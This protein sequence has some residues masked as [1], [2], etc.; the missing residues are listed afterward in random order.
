[1]SNLQTY[2]HFKIYLKKVDQ[3]TSGKWLTHGTKH[4]EDIPLQSLPLPCRIS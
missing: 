2:Y 4:R 3:D 1:M